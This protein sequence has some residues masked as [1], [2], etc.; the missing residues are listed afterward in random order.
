M[1]VS[2]NSV[3]PP[4]APAELLSPIL[5]AL[6]PAAASKEPATAV[7]LLLS[8]ILRQ[9]VKFLAPS[10]A[11]PWLHLLCY[12]PAKAARL[13]DVAKSSRL[14]PHPVSGEVEV[15]WDHDV[16]TRF[17]RL[18]SET[19]QALVVLREL[20][21]SFQLVYCFGDAEGGGDG[22]RIGEVSVASTPSPFTVFGQATTIAQAE[23]VFASGKS[24]KPAV[25]TNGGTANGNGTHQS[26]D[27]QEED[28]DD[29]DDDDAGYWDRYDATPSRTPAQKASPAP[30]AAGGPVQAPARNGYSQAAADEDEYYAQY[31][32]VQP[33][34]DNHDPDEEAAAQHYAPPLGLAPVQRPSFGSSGVVPPVGING[35]D[36]PAA[37]RERIAHDLLHPRPESSASSSGSQTVARLEVE[38]GRQETNEFGVKQHISRSVRSLFQLSRVSGIDREEFERIVKTE[39]DLLGLMG[40]M[41]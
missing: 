5:P 19:L 24:A 15:D 40:D 18:D 25:H 31:D 16:D 23:E 3:I 17:R 35:G 22:W 28:N 38:A 2:K 30:H 41:D 12:D 34:M 4:P 26:N 1:A 29:D 6:A 11:D 7:L 10:S 21:L 14:D 27:A 36:S 9:R 33:A 32:D 13:V 37:D 20:G 8:P 39:I